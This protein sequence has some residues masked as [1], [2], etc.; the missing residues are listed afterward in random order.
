MPPTLFFLLR[1]ALAVQDILWVHTTF[2]MVF[3]TSVENITDILMGI[4]S[5]L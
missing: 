5:N 2:Q 1:V 3:A 4:A